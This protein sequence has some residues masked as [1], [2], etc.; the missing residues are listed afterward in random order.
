MFPVAP[1]LVE[2][3]QDYPTWLAELKRRIQEERLRIVLAS[4]TAMVLLYWDI[5]QSILEKQNAQGWGAKIIDRLSTDLRDAFPE[6][7]DFLLVTSNTC[8]LLQ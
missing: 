7:K 3:P 8:V 6:M 1:S 2:L 5:G 4:N